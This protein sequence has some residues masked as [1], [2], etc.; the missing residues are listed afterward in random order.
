MMSKILV[1]NGPNLNFL[2]KRN[3]DIYGSD[4]LADVEYKIRD[5]ITCADLELVF[6]QSNHEGELIDLIQDHH[7]SLNGIAIN[8]GALTHYGYSLKDALIDAGVPVVEVHVGNPYAREEWRRHSVIADTAIGIIS[9]F[10]WR[11]YKLAI[12][13]IL[14]HQ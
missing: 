14:E 6:F 4:T 5:A 1:I 11:S 2:G 7:G 3:P 10:G 12:D 13:A 8:A 9:G